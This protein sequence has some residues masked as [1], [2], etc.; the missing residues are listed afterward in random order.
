M[1][2][3][4]MAGSAWWRALGSRALISSALISSA[5]GVG[6]CLL[7]CSSLPDVSAQA[8]GGATGTF[9]GH[10]TVFVTGA[11]EAPLAGAL[12]RV[13]DLEATT[14]SDGRVD[15]ELDGYDGVEVSHD[16]R[17]ERWLGLS[18]AVVTVPLERDVEPNSGTLSGSL[19]L[20]D[21]APED[22]ANHL[23]AIVSASHTR[24]LD[25]N[26]PSASV[27]CPDAADCAFMFRVPLSSRRVFAE[28]L[29]LDADDTVVRVRGLFLSDPVD[30]IA[31]ETSVELLPV[32]APV[33][34]DV[35]APA[36]GEAFDE[37]VGVPGAT[38]DGAAVL[39]FSEDAMGLARLLPPGA[40]AVW[41]VAVGRRG[42]AV[43]RSVVRTAEL[44]DALSPP[45]LS[46]L[47]E[48]ALDGDGVTLEEASYRVLR[49]GSDTVRVFDGRTRVPRPDGE[50]ITVEVTDVDMVPN[51]FSLDAIETD[52]VHRVRATL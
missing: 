3:D 28:V 33:T 23:S 40:N 8:G 1:L 4:V 22:P 29:E 31:G 12:V 17:S 52:W 36:G 20:G 49:A 15:F 9:D 16:G 14:G 18:G 7:G 47:P 39:L 24:Q 13:E 30:V 34:L 26:A 19:A 11:A 10:L 51:D 38:L 42:G 35:S 46:A 25:R 32:D 21:L 43:S 5:L 48:A 37:V 41:A 6:A 27:R 50:E 45:A 2:A 44:S